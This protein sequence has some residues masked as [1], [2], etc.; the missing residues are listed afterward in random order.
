[1]YEE[2]S[3]KKRD[4]DDRHKKRKEKKPKEGPIDRNPNILQI[5]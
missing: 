4:Q 1:M 5:T 3:E 2:L